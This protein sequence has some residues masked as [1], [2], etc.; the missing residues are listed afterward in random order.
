MDKGTDSS[1]EL[2][3]LFVCSDFAAEERLTEHI[4]IPK[5]E[6]NKSETTTVQIDEP[7]PGHNIS[8]LKKET[9]GENIDGMS[10]QINPYFSNECNKP[11]TDSEFHMS[12]TKEQTIVEIPNTQDPLTRINERIV[13]PHSC[14]DCYKSSTDLDGLLDQQD[15]HVDFL[16]LSSNFVKQK[17]FFCLYWL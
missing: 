10:L 9:S 12:H 3:N 8:L 13:R 16:D 11:V 7:S 1:D 2:F 6:Q 4:V 15:K 17:H 14:R 5:T